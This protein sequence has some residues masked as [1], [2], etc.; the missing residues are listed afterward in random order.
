MPVLWGKKKISPRRE[1]LE[2]LSYIWGRERRKIIAVE[3]AD[4]SCRGGGTLA[5]GKME[6]DRDWRKGKEARLKGEKGSEVGEKTPLAWRKL[7]GSRGAHGKS[8]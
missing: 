2:N 8:S 3:D 6:R 5:G 4:S 7:K 1:D